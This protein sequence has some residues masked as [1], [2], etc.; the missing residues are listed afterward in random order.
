MLLLEL[1]NV[2][3]GIYNLVAVLKKI[4]IAVCCCPVVEKDVPR[5]KD[6]DFT[7]HNRVK[8]KGSSRYQ[9]KET[10][11]LSGIYRAYN[12]TYCTVLLT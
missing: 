7:V 11:K 10:L 5:Q 3:V 1:I 12:S 2:A 9:L 8:V 6:A 4:L